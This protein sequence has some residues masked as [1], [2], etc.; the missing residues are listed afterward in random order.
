[1]KLFH[2]RELSQK[3][4][5]ARRTFLKALGIGI[6]APLA[7]KMSRLAVAQS[8]EPIKR[9]FLFYLPH[10]APIEHWDVSEDLAL[11][12]NGIGMLKPLEPYKQ[13]LTVMRGVSNVVMD[14]HDAI[15]SVFTGKDESPS[16]DFHI[17]SALG[18]TPH[19]LGV[20]NFWPGSTSLSND[21]KLIN[22]G[23]WVVP[24]Q[25]PFDA[26]NDMFEGI[27]AADA[28]QGVDE[29]QFRN[30]ALDLSIGELEAMQKGVTELTTEKNKLQVH[31][32]SLR[33]LKGAG[34]GT[35]G[36]D[37]RPDEAMP[38]ALAMQGKDAQADANV[39]L[40]LDGH[41]EVAAQAI[42]CGTA[43]VASLQ[44]LHANAQVPMNFEG[45]PGYAK[46]HHDPLSHSSDTAGGAEFAMTQQ[47]FY[48]RLA[49]KFLAAL[50]VP[51][52]LNAG[53]TVLDNTIV[54]TSSEICDGAN[55]NSKAGELWM[56]DNGG[57]Q[58]FLPSVI[59]GKGGGFFKGN[60]VV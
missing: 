23:G 60:Q 20:R 45:G 10:G 34:V 53:S 19:V 22:H 57:R 46:N 25:N 47:W 58:T 36:C 13:Y 41:L 9:L 43:R 28:P 31:L 16:I 8:A 14:N 35:L 38:S 42:R 55:H 56:R 5:L 11:D 48:S 54:L 26:M 21:A 32:E 18:V 17:A 2:S 15:R 3:Q 4:T 51:D 50:D 27:G 52:P 44:I 33:A 59:I 37:A 6:A 7:F 30:E 12:A 24:V 40:S 1:M 29:L 49:E 39:G